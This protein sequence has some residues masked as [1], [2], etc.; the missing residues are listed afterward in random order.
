MKTAFLKFSKDD[1]GD[2]DKD[3]HHKDIYQKMTKAKTNTTTIKLGKY[4]YVLSLKPFFP[5]LPKKIQK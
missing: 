1:K 4:S 5:L 3:Y 2:Y